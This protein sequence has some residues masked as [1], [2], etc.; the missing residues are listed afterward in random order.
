MGMDSDERY[1]RMALGLAFRGAG[2]T[3]PNPIVGAVLVRRGRVVGS[4]YHQSS[5]GDHAEIIALKRAG[6]SANRSTLYINLEPCDH[7]GKTPPCTEGIIAAGIK[8]VVMGIRDPN[9]LVSGKGIRSLRENGIEVV[10]GV[11]KRDCERLNE[12]FLKYIHTWLSNLWMKFL[13]MI[14]HKLLSQQHLI[15]D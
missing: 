7:Q 9:R 8:K 11:L 4:G 15:E 3:S 1:L 6:Q 10:T 2:R 14:H 5:G 13:P 12:S